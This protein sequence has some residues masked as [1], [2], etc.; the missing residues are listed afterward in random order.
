[1]VERLRTSLILEIKPNSKNT[2][3]PWDIVVQEMPSG[4]VYRLTLRELG[5]VSILLQ[6][7]ISSAW[8]QRLEEV[9]ARSGTG[10]VHKASQV[11]V[12]EGKDIRLL[13]VQD[14]IFVE[15]CKGRYTLFHT[16]QGVYFCRKKLKEVEKELSRCGFFLRTHRAYL[17]NMSKIERIIPYGNNIYEVRFNNY[18]VS[19]WI[20]RKGMRLVK[21]WLSNK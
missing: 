20:S 19:A 18:N 12:L 17:I 15:T 21:K 1:M 13:N 7:L 3:E 16:I 4:K 10:E 9:K 6:R 11:Y 2:E 8:P 14:I 5:E